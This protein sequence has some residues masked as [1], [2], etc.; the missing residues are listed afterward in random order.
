MS[1][2]DAQSWQVHMN[3]IRTAYQSR[4]LKA[5]RDGREGV[6][7]FMAREHNF[8]ATY[9]NSCVQAALAHNTNPLGRKAQY[10]RKFRE[11]NFHKRPQDKDWKTLGKVIK[12]RER[13]GKKSSVFTGGFLVP[14]STIKKELSRQGYMTATE[15][16]EAHQGTKGAEVNLYFTH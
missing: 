4:P 2:P 15:L 11:W 10:E 14:E 16:A 13:I 12:R 7:E 9:V 6:I 5:G 1:K 8:V 3:T